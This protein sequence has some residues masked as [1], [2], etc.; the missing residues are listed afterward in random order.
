M[1]VFE[2]SPSFLVLDQ[3]LDRLSGVLSG[4]FFDLDK[5]TRTTAR[6]VGLAVRPSL[7][8][9]RVQ[10]GAIIAAVRRRDDDLGKPATSA[11]QLRP[12]ATRA[13]HGGVDAFDCGAGSA[14]PGPS[15]LARRLTAADATQRLPRLDSIYTART[16]F[17][18]SV[19]LA[20]AA[21]R[22]SSSSSTVGTRMANRLAGRQ[23]GG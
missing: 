4:K 8:G 17:G 14:K 2:V 3:A 22:R 23:T 20:M 18:Q 12:I 5:T 16:P 7:G 19:E 1:R 6:I 13:W 15:M 10:C 11:P 21:A 9:S